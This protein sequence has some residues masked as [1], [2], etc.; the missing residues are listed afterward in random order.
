[1]HR[2]LDPA[3]SG[4]GVQF[5]FTAMA[6]SVAELVVVLEAVVVE[7]VDVVL[8]V[9]VDVVLELVVLLSEVVVGGGITVVV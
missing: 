4:E 8:E 5:T 7:V 1:M 6:R 3:C 9:V 2:A